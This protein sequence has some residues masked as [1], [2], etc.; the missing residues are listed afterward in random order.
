MFYVMEKKRILKWILAFGAL[1]LT[2]FTPAALAQTYIN[3]SASGN[4]LN[5][6]ISGASYGQTV[7]LV[8][9][10]PGSSLQTVI[11][12]I[13]TIYSG[14]WNGTLNLN[15]YGIVPGSQVFVRVGGQQSD[16]ITV[17]SNYGGCTYNC[18]SPFGLSLSQNQVNL[19]VGQSRA[20]SAYNYGS[21]IYIS[22]NSNP[23]V[24]SVSVSGNQVN[25]Y[26]LMNGSST[27][28]VCSS[29]YGY[30]CASIYV[31]VSGSVAGVSTY[32][33]SIRDNFFSP[34]IIT[35]PLGSS[36][37]W[38]NDGFLAHTV[39]FDNPYSDSGTIYAGGSY[40]KTFSQRGTYTYRCR[41]HPGMTGTVV[42]TDSTGTGNLWFNPANPNLY[43]GQSLA[44]SINSS[45]FESG[46]LGSSQAYYISSNSNPAVVTATVAGTVLNLYAN[47]A[48][49]STITVCHSALNFCG[50]LD[51]VVRGDYGGSLYLSQSSLQLS[52]SQSAVVSIYGSGSYYISSNTNPNVAGAAV[53]G[54]NLNVYAYSPG[55]TVISICQRDN[56]QCASLS[57]TV[58]GWGSGDIHIINTVL[59]VMT[60]G[61]YYSQ[62][63]Q[64][65]GGVPP[66]TFALAGGAL[67][68]G[69]NLSASGLIYGVPVYAYTANFNVRVT[70]SQGKSGIIPLTISA[71]PTGGGIIY[72][73]GV[74]G[75]A[76][77]KNGQLIKEGKTIYIVY[78]GMKTGFGNWSAFVGFGF[79][80]SSVIDVGNS[81]LAD[82]GYVITTSQTSHPWGSWI[83][84]GQ[85]V[86][87]VY[88]TGLIPIPDWNIFINNGG[89]AHLIV[90]AN[91]KDF[92][93]P[94]L[95]LMVGDDARL[96]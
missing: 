93:L 96:K 62:Q 15:E 38:R 54:S 53:A 95:S 45:V 3:I 7:D 48:G 89:Q 82:S 25:L 19:T 72:P 10:L 12:N 63:L 34:Q 4:I 76:V 79:K 73:G 92:S 30:G 80:L 37:I 77:Y 5:V 69:L 50:T 24:V 84:S 1:T 94:I 26:G 17:G 46:S 57:V 90:D 87:F 88:E 49:L 28:T 65:A 23:A 71:G 27:V 11:S 39:T 35:I 60:A 83:K 56:Y 55:T 51:V 91:L 21:G 58:S 16:I 78:R 18:G 44:V 47:R 74:L 9:S 13:A 52:S 22:S 85:T 75:A 6:S 67:P 33:V 86:Y 41:F 8:Y 66:Y 20:V 42:V 2:S 36:V 43:V 64:A 40:T 29:T 81:G 59:P 68:A 32:S 70:D 31:T 61:Q 14:T